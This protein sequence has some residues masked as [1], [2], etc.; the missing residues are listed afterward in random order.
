M[1]YQRRGTILTLRNYIIKNMVCVPCSWSFMKGR[2]HLFDNV[3][4]EME[5]GK[6]R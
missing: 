4:F 3:G 2:P 6:P 5:F 1:L